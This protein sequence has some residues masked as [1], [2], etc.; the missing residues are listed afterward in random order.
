MK[1][2]FVTLCVLSFG[3]IASAGD[4]DR[5]ITAI[6]RLEARIARLES[7]GQSYSPP[8]QQVRYQQASYSRPV[9]RATY[10]PPSEESYSR[11]ILQEAYSR[12][13]RYSDDSDSC[14]ESRP[15]RMYCVCTDD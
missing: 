11:P 2:L 9:Q 12:S 14:R 7:G 3:S 15:R 1:K 13:Q 5:V 4:L 6:E 10:S 8:A